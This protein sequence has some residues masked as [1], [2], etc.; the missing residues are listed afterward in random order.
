MINHDQ[1]ER[2]KKVLPRL[3]NRKRELCQCADCVGMP[4]EKEMM[5]FLTK[6]GAY[7]FELSPNYKTWWITGY[8]DG[9][10]SQHKD[11]TEALVQAVEAVKLQKKNKKELK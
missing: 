2:L 8:G 6:N 11:L 1:F 3:V 10:W 9:V 7:T 4:D 5:E